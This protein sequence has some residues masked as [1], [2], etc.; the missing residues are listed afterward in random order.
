LDPDVLDAYKLEGPGWQAHMNEVLRQ[1]IA[2]A[3]EMI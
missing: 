3:R 2:S 1:H